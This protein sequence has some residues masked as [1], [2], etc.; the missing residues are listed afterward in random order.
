MTRLMAAGLKSREGEAKIARTVGI[1]AIMSAARIV[2][3]M[4]NTAPRNFIFGGGGEVGSKNQNHQTNPKTNTTV[5]P[6]QQMSITAVA[7][8]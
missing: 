4:S 6:T 8:K 7:S 2:S 1:K 3:T 5:N